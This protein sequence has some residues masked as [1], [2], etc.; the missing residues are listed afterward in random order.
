MT[1]IEKKLS[2][3][4]GSGVVLDTV[5]AVLKVPEAGGGVD[6]VIVNV[7]VP[8]ARVAAVQVTVGERAPGAIELHDQPPGTLSDRNTLPAG[9]G[10]VREGLA[11]S[12]GPSLF[13]LMT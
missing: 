9:S 10:K 8:G 2:F 6:A 13:T 5:A 4:F 3:R 12:A 7:A 1:S 11:A